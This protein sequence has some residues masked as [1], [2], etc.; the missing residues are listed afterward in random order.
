MRLFISVEVP[1]NIAHSIKRLQQIIGEQ[2]LFVGSYVRPSHLHITLAFL[3]EI[4]PDSLPEIT[5]ALH[6]VSAHSFSFSLETLTVNSWHHPHVLWFSINCPELTLL[7]EQIARVLPMAL[8]PRPFHGHVTIARI[9]RLLRGDE[10]RK[11]FESMAIARM[12]WHVTHF[13]L[14]EST[15]TPTGS[16]Y[17]TIESFKL[18]A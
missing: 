2:E 13:N 7:A 17:R 16:N 4:D 18:K 12:H 1:E 5:C 14:K 10:L 8:E 15:L 11:L 6:L 3:G 9:K